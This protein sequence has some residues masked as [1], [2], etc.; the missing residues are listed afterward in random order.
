MMLPQRRSQLFDS[1]REV[2]ASRGRIDLDALSGML[3]STVQRAIGHWAAK[4]DY[5]STLIADCLDAVYWCGFMTADNSV[6]LG[7]QV[8]TRRQLD[9]DAETQLI[10]SL[11]WAFDI[12][13]LNVHVASTEDLLTGGN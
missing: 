2:F 11:R 5:P 10:N 9:L 12:S 6:E 13:G 1:G 7:L 8:V 3:Q 4:V